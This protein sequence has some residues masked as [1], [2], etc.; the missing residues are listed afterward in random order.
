MD[1][2]VNLWVFEKPGM[3]GEELVSMMMWITKYKTDQK[4]ISSDTL[5]Y[6]I[7]LKEDFIY[8]G[9]YTYKQLPTREFRR[10]HR[11]FQI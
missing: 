6:A 5:C 8:V 2:N 1:K 4:L 3:N 9:A 10:R 7:L 11:E